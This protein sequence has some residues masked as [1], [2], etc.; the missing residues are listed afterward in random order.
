M[1]GCTQLAQWKTLQAHYQQIKDLHLRDMFRNDPQRGR[2]FSLRLGDIFFDYSKN[3]IGK[4]TLA[5]LVDLAEKME[6]P[7]KIEALFGG[8]KINITEN[9][10][11][12]HT[13]LRNESG[14]PVWVD[15]CDV[16]PAVFEVRKKMRHFSEQVRQGRWLGHTGKSVTDV[17][18]IG[19]GGSDLGP[20]MVCSALSFYASSRL[21]VHFVSNVDGSHMAQTL[22]DLNPETT[23]FLVASKTF[24][25]QETMVNATAAR[26]WLLDELED[27]S[28]VARHFVALSA[29]RDAVQAFGI[30]PDNMFVFW[31][32]VGGRYSLW[33]AIGLS[34]AISIGMDGFEQLLHGAFCVDEHFRTA[35][36]SRNI[37][38]IMALLGIWYINFFGT[39]THAVLPYEQYLHRFPAYLQ[40]ADMESNGK[41]V[42]ALGST[43]D[44]CTGPVL[45][46]E[47][48]TNSQH[49]FFQLLHQGTHLVPC[50]FLIGATPLHET[51][52]QHDLLFANFL[53]QT[54]A[55]MRGKDCQQVEKE[56]LAAGKTVDEAKALSPHKTFPGNRPSSSFLYRKLTPE[57][58]GM[59]IALYEHKI[60]VQGVIWGVNS[61]DQMGVEFGKELAQS[62]IPVLQ[63]TDSGAEHDSSTQNLLRVWK[64]FSGARQSEGPCF[65]S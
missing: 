7:E 63:G 30:D 27:K 16:M 23:L 15:G 32:W 40:Q 62:L 38:V 21:R 48:G 26:T 6:L 9:R 61:F 14:Q 22:A 12:L 64:E 25:T 53:A 8:Q 11:V 56:L 13:A 54:E 20:Q 29:N 39:T 36:L 60:F 59:L 24:T 58:L 52:N 18:N 17:V 42:N 33:S 19:I 47:P 37:P 41:G 46:G 3:R 34:I 5:L 4:Q 55:L 65:I 50:D 43:V 49:A 35:P 57:V 28:A 10:A 2:L 45:W 31:D 1:V 51:D 44:Y